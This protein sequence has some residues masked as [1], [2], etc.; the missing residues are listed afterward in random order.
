MLCP[1]C[2]SANAANR[3]V[4]AACGTPLA[5]GDLPRDVAEAPVLPAGDP[6]V[7][8]IPAA[9]MPEA[10]NRS[11]ELHLDGLYRLAKSS[12]LRLSYGFK[13]LSS[14]DYLYDGLRFGS[15][16]TAM[17]TAEQAP[18]Y[19]VHVFGISYVFTFH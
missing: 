18:G 3:T 15:Q 17:P 4:C 2:N 9:D 6:A 5:Q 7:L 11:F 14:S 8:F 19:S 1:V 13:H 10:V 12:S 16:T